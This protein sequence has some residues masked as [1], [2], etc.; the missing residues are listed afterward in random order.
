MPDFNSFK[1]SIVDWVLTEDKTNH[2]LYRHQALSDVMA[3][4]ITLSPPKD[5]PKKYPDIRNLTDFYM[6]IAA[7]QGGQLIEVSLRAIDGI[8]AIKTITQSPMPN[9]P[10]TIRYVGAWIFPL[11]DFYSSI[12]FQCVDSSASHPL[13]RVYRYLHE[14]PDKISIGYDVKHAKPFRW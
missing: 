4:G 10:R 8:E 5:L 12:H 13:T 1:L 14:L 11:E 3:H 2:H 7:R 9:D 6:D